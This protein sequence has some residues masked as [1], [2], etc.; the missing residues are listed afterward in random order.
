MLSNNL[1]GLCDLWTK[2]VATPSNS[3]VEQIF[4]LLGYPSIFMESWLVN[5]A[6]IVEEKK[7]LI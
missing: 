6:L 3:R 5:V 7:L 2:G 4:S 1:F